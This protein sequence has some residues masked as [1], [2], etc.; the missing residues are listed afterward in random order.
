MPKPKLLISVIILNSKEDK[1]LLIKKKHKDYYQFFDKELEIGEEFLTSAINIVENYLN[2][3]IELKKERFKYICCFNAV[4][5]DI[6]SH[7]V[8]INYLLIS[9]NEDDKIFNDFNC[10]KYNIYDV[11]WFSFDELK[12]TNL[13]YGIEIFINKFKIENFIQIKNILSN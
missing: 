5:K 11:K 9:T 1:V 10:Y 2:Y 3:N 4:K 13:F 7:Y 12:N 6:N 8:I